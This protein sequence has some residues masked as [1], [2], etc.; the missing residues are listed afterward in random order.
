MSHQVIPCVT[1]LT[2]HSV[3]LSSLFFY[4]LITN[5]TPWQSNK[6]SEMTTQNKVPLGNNQYDIHYQNLYQVKYMWAFQCK[7]SLQPGGRLNKKDSLTR[8]GNSHVKDKT[9]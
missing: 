5:S 1:N 6:I 2:Y 7:H 4:L 8:Y 9:S 3:I